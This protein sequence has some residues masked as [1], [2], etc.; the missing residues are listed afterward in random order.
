MLTIWANG[1]SR[2]AV[3]IPPKRFWHIADRPTPWQE[4]LPCRKSAGNSP[5]LL[6]DQ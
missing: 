3:A 5:E 6:S 1:K 4:N 2:V